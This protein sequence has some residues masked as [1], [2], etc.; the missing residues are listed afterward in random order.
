ML[1]DKL[2]EA[3]K[4]YTILCT[5]AS[6]AMVE[7]AKARVSDPN[8]EFRVMDGQDIS[9]VAEKTVDGINCFS[10]LMF[11]PDP[12]QC[13]R[14]MHRVLKKG[15]LATVGTWSRTELGVV[16]DKFGRYLGALGDD[17]VSPGYTLLQVVH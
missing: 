15:A 5:D 14:E 9:G 1:G 4:E 13:L 11:M 6:L 7:I 3:G 12:A 16:A 17:D 10:A 8:V 2:R